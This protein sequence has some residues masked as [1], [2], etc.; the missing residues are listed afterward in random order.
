LIGFILAAVAELG[1]WVL[2]VPRWASGRS[3]D[4]ASGT[5]L[6][7]V[8]PDG[9]RLS[10]RWFPAA[11]DRDSLG[12]ILLL[13]GFGESASQLA[14]ARFPEL[15][16]AGWD[17][18]VPDSRGYGE[19]AGP[20]ATF[21]AREAGDVRAWIDRLQKPELST[22]SAKSRPV[23][24]WGRS[25]GGAIAARAAAGDPRISALILESPLLDLHAAVAIILR[26][27]RLPGS[28]FLAR[29]VLRRANRLARVALDRPRLDEVAP[30]IKC[31]VLI[32]QGTED[33]L[34]S[35]DK[36]RAL[37]GRFA[38]PAE[39]V[40]I[41][42]AGHTDVVGVGGDGLWRQILGFLNPKPLFLKGVM[43]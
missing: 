7:V 21:G 25:M 2:L 33:S 1:A 19:S 37:A 35:M 5:P 9:A 41:A 20:L 11:S 38:R 23:I 6:S 8:A 29:R 43:E 34:A 28:R 17:V 30:K 24:V 42:G 39:V 15:T 10:G 26:N 40:E 4:L 14:A 12:S 32:V 31:P 18:A 27:R 22:E 16:R 13:H 3:E 36:V